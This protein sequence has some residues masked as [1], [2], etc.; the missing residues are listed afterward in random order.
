MRAELD[1]LMVAAWTKIEDKVLNDP[2]DLRRRL[3]RRRSIMFQHIPRALCL[4]LKAADHRLNPTKPPSTPT[5]H[6]V[7]LDDSLV[8]HLCRPVKIAWPG[9]PLTDIQKYLGCSYSAM[10][11][12]QHKGLLRT[13]SIKGLAGRRG[14]P[15]VVAMSD[16]PLDPSTNLHTT[17]D[18][19]L[20]P[21]WNQLEAYIRSDLRQSITRRPLFRLVRGQRRHSGW[22]WVCPTCGQQ[23]RTLY[24]PI[25]VPDWAKSHQININPDDLQHIPTP[26]GS[27]ACK[28][29]H[30]VI[31]FTRT[32]KA[33]IT[34]WNFLIMHLSSGLLF[35]HEVAMPTWFT[36]TRKH[37]YTPRKKASPRRDELEHLLATTTLPAKEIARRMGLTLSTIKWTASHIYKRRRVNKR[38][39]LKLWYA[40]H[41]P[42]SPRATL[43]A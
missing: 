16:L 39:G 27:F 15:V 13:R 17:P 9:E 5:Q 28:H 38:Q 23:A 41:I 3:D 4:A 31:G 8:M 35:G 19:L 30:G 12:M 10:K 14:R 33:I 1:R 25:G 22:I 11:R 24:Y 29:C 42:H 40:R 21:Y 36:P 43:A 18:P 34:H 20:A 26:P 7:L 2:A 6:Q 32:E 37:Q